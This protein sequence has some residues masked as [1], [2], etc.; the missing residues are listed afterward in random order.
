MSFEKQRREMIADIEAGVTATRHLTGRDRLDD[1]V[2]DALARVHR[3]D[4]VPPAR[5]AD[6]FRDGALPVGYGQTISQP[7]MVAL[8]TDLLEL[9]EDSKVLEIGTGTGYQAAILSCLARQVYS[10]ERI[11]ELADSARERL[12]DLGYRNVEVRCG[13]GNLGWPEQAPFD[14]IVV[15]AA[16]PSVPP[17]LIEQLDPD[18]RM[19]IPV[20]MPASHQELMLVTHDLEGKAKIRSLLAVAFVPM[21]EDS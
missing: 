13:D 17:R 18:G 5:R 20:G 7:Y 4:F 15:T 10:I 21:I 3:E 9:N 16:A 12:G 19:V 2:L 11:P 14:A 1:R 6:A 8:M